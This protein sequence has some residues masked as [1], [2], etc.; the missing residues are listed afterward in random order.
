MFLKCTDCLATYDSV[1]C[2]LWVFILILISIVHEHYMGISDI[3]A[4]LVT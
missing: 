3:I 1:L 4:D 2:N